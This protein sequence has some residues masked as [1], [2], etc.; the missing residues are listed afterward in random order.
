VVV[1]EYP[2]LRGKVVPA[3]TFDKVSRAVQEYRAARK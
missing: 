3:D 1:K 2:S